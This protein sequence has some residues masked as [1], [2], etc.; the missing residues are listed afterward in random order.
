MRGAMKVESQGKVTLFV[1]QLFG[2]LLT[3][4]REVVFQACFNEIVFSLLFCGGEHKTQLSL[5]RVL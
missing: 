4:H 3:I 1:F 2:L 5:D